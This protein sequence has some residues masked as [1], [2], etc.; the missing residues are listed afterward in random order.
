MIQLIVQSRAL[1]S[2]ILKTSFG[3]EEVISPYSLY[4]ISLSNT[5]WTHKLI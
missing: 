2:A 3:I 1:H 4:E 5:P